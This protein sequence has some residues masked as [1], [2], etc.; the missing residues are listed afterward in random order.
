MRR[1]TLAT[2]NRA[3]ALAGEPRITRPTFGGPLFKDFYFT[4]DYQAPYHSPACVALNTAVIRSYKPKLV[5]LGGDMVDFVSISS[6]TKFGRF[7]PAHVAHE[8][9]IYEA[10]VLR[11]LVSASRDVGAE[12]WHIEGNHEFR[13]PRY[14]AQYAKA[15][16]GMINTGDALFCK[17]YGIKYF[18][19]KGGNGIAR[20]NDNLYAMHGEAGGARP[21]KAQYDKFRKSL[22]MGHTHKEDSYRNNN[23][24]G[25]DHLSLAAGCNCIASTFADIDGYTRGSIFGWFETSGEQRFDMHHLRII[26]DNH[27][28]VVSPIGN[29][30]AICTKQNHTGRIVWSAQRSKDSR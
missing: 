30:K 19:S 23:G 7:S 20:L 8:L 25:G 2:A 3:G 27:N 4:S 17:K 10:E 15:L 18:A 1:D 21:A 11:P 26:G 24:V 9:E 13:L 22:M 14:I 28:E 6:F 12:I 5:I 16:E 29:F